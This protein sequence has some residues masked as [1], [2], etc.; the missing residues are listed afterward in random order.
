MDAKVYSSD[1]IL[2]LDDL[3]EIQENG[4]CRYQLT[5]GEIGWLN[6]V[7]GRYS[8]A[9]VI[10]NNLDDGI[11]YL[12]CDEISQALDEDCGHYGKAV[13]LADDT[14]LQKILFWLYTEYS[15]DD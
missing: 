3:Y 8:I 14:A 2:A 10:D 15:N 9:D 1:E 5:D 7:R 4:N 6:F 12:D 13:C 11:V